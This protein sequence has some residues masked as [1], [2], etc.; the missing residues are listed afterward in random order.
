MIKKDEL[1]KRM[2][3]IKSK[4]K[5]QLKAIKDDGEKQLKILTNQDKIRAP[6]LTPWLPS[7]NGLT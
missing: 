5:E 1:L 3:Y 6:L 2:R 4:N 7:H